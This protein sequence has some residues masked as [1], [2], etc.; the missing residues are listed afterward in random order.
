MAYYYINL[1]ELIFIRY[2]FNYY[3]PNQLFIRI[4]NKNKFHIRYALIFFSDQ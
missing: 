3:N 2:L 1:Q 4:V